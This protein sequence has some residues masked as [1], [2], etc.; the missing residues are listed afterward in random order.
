MENDSKSPAAIMGAVLSVLGALLYGLDCVVCDVRRY[1]RQEYAHTQE[2]DLK[3]LA[4][5]NSLS[6]QAGQGAESVRFNCLSR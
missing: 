1:I 3:I 4:Q 5:L 6:V 2:H